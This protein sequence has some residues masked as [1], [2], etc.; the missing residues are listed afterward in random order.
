MLF[1]D[2]VTQIGILSG[3]LGIIFSIIRF[4]K[5]ISKPIE[6]NALFTRE[7]SAKMDEHIKASYVSNEKIDKIAESVNRTDEKLNSHMENSKE[8]RL[9][10]SAK[11]DSNTHTLNKVMEEMAAIDNR[12]DNLEKGKKS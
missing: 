3:I 1:L 12:M 6:E 7:V 11:T 4:Y 10:I 5:L 9:D 8:F 2:I